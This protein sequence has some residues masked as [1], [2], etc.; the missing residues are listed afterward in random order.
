[1]N[2]VP[3]RRTGGGRHHP[4]VGRDAFRTCICTAV[5]WNNP[6]AAASAPWQPE[7]AGRREPSPL[8]SPR[9]HPRPIQHRR[10]WACLRQR[11]CDSSERQVSS[12]TFPERAPAKVRSTLPASWPEI[13]DAASAFE[14]A[15]GAIPWR[16]DVQLNAVLIG[17]YPINS[18]D[19]VPAK[20]PSI[21]QSFASIEMKGKIF[22]L[23]VLHAA[24]VR[25]AQR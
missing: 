15:T 13:R 16:N 25:S 11:P 1:M 24:I 23:D 8:R 2:C 19:G 22:F 6:A 3:S 9:S 20:P 7:V 14:V 10:L 5:A 18:P 21:L 12:T 4:H 17:I